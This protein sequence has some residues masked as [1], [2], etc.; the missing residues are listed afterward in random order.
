MAPTSAGGRALPRVLLLTTIDRTMAHHLQPLVRALKAQS[1]A[2]ELACRRT[3][4]ALW[5]RL[6]DLD[7]RLHDVSFSRR[8]LHPRN[9][10]A[11]C[12]VVG[13]LRRG[14]Y[15]VV[16]AHTAVA[17][18][19]ARL[20]SQM[21]GRRSVLIYS[22]HGLQFAAGLSPWRNAVVIALEKIAAR[23]TDYLVVINR[24]DE[25]AAVRYHLAPTGRVRY[26]PGTGIDSAVFDP[27]GVDAAQVEAVRR[28]LGLGVDDVLFLVVGEFTRRKRQVDTLSALALL[29]DAHVHV[30]FA[31]SGCHMSRVQQMGGRLGLQSVT[32][33][34]GYRRDVAAL[35]L[36]S[37]ASILASSTEGVPKSVMESLA[38][39]VPAIGTDV[40]GTRE[41]L[42]DGCGIVVPLGDAPALAGAMRWMADH[43]QEAAAMGRAGRQ[44]I[45]ERYDL[46]RVLQAQ[47]AMFR[48][49]LASQARSSQA[50]GTGA[51]CRT[52][53]PD[54]GTTNGSAGS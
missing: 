21:S 48:E 37:R 40:R 8:P 1:Y 41:L 32:H 15:V 43:A 31:G 49:A 25:A 42:Q 12:Q 3:D 20:A 54:G 28:E 39:Q 38:L 33:F 2:V 4:D 26:L 16:D 34:L 17:G 51:V 45:L 9:L 11:L 5:S 53:P 50:S 18:W 22:T 29:D 47:L 27:Q 23:W 35:L 52:S 24:E 44:K 30:A 6:Q 46:Q 10:R 19:V 14:G 36:A 13:L 7:V